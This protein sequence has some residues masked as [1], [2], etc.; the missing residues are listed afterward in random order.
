MAH[1]SLQEMESTTQVQIPDKA[2]CISLRINTLG[3]CMNP[4]LLPVMSK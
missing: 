4:Y 1:L 2:S 3:K